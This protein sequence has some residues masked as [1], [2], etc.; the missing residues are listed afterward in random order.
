VKVYVA[1]QG[2]KI[3]EQSNTKGFYDQSER[4]RNPANFAQGALS[5]DELSRLPTLGA[6]EEP[7]PR[8]KLTSLAGPHLHTVGQKHI[9]AEMG[10]YH[11]LP[12]ITSI[13]VFWAFDEEGKLIDIWVWK[14][15]DGL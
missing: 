14:T 10:H 12:F 7:D 8:P 1:K 13:S 4:W 11:T 9:R 3:T 15:V 2:W 5:P 6:S